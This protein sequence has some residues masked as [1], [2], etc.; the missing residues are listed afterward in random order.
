MSLVPDR[1]YP[2]QVLTVAD[3][4]EVHPERGN[5]YALS[6]D[7]PPKQLYLVRAEV[8]G[9]AVE[10]I[11]LG[12]VPGARA[13]EPT[14]GNMKRALTTSIIS[15][16]AQKGYRLSDRSEMVIDTDTRYNSGLGVP[17]LHGHSIVGLA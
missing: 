15:G 14:I 6:I 4:I 7:E 9:K 13:V 1:V 12:K 3:A 8:A 10:N 5:I 2:A 16:L 17:P 11:Y